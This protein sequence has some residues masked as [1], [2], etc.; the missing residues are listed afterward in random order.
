MFCTY[1]H[2]SKCIQ[3]L[4]QS[5]RFQPVTPIL[6]GPINKDREGLIELGI[7]IL[8]LNGPSDDCCDASKCN[9]LHQLYAHLQARMWVKGTCKYMQ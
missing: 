4:I 9:I 8:L 7:R 5:N 3:N 2:D 1:V 6:K